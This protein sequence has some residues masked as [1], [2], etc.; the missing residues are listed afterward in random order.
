LLSFGGASCVFQIAIQIYK[1]KIYR[2]IILPVVLYGCENWSLTF[3]EGLR[4]KVCENRVLR[5]IFWP[6]V[7]KLTGS[8]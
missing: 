5:G 3:R 8:G 1:I 2:K 7:D 6:E 4:V